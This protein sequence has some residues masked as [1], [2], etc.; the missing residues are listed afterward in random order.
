MGMP[1]PEAQKYI[2]Q[3]VEGTEYLHAR[4]V[5]HRDLKPENLLLDSE[6]ELALFTDGGNSLSI[7]KDRW[8]RSRQG[9]YR[10]Y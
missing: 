1:Q 10:G 2:R 9:L 6:G 7:T 4:G 3:L 8:S 5:V